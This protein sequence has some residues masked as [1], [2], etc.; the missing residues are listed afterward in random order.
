MRELRSIFRVRTPWG[1]R[2]HHRYFGK[3]SSHPLR[4]AIRWFFERLHTALSRVEAMIMWG[5][6]LVNK[7]F[8]FDGFN[9]GCGDLV[10]EVL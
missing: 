8:S 6:E 4:I 5:R 10:I 1:I 2:W 3:R 7:L 9:K